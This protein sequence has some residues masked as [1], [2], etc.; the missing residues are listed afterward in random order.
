MI[1][2]IK[3]G[4]LRSTVIIIASLIVLAFSGCKNNTS[5]S[6]IKI[7]EKSGS[8]DENENETE[9][10]LPVIVITDL[11]E[12]TV[13]TGEIEVVPEE[14][15][16]PETVSENEAK[17]DEEKEDPEKEDEEDNNEETEEGDQETAN[18]NRPVTGNGRLIAIDAGHQS[19]GNSS[20][21]PVGPGASQTKAKVTG[22]TRGVATGLT[23]YELNLQVSLKLRDELRARGYEVLMIRES[24][25][26]NI[27]NAERA[28]I[29]NDAG[30]AAFVRIHANGSEN[31]SARGMM[32]ICQTSSNPYNANLYPQ[33]KEL[34][35]D[36]LDCMVAATGAKREKVWETDTM[37]GIN[38]CQTPATI[39]EMGYM[40]N[41]EEDRL[42]ASD[43]YQYKIVKG[44]ADGIDRFMANR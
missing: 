38:W 19:K 23:E 20:K 39:I 16:D 27:S 10:E 21:E 41:P 26:V 11:E 12:E 24:N 9:S 15:E 17:A 6:S 28:Q 5:D 2:T 25:D 40:T 7:I 42:M 29:A 22:G 43:D 14:D 44:I 1:S 32:T 4:F 37:T 34:S 30:A 31:S 35:T 8:E 36:I 18:E 3:S 13:K 33:S